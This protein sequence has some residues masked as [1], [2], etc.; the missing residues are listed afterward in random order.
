MLAYLLVFLLFQVLFSKPYYC[1]IICEASL[2]CL[3]DTILQQISRHSGTYSLY[4]VSSLIFS[5]P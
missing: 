3:G 2:T 4:A 5:E 1:G